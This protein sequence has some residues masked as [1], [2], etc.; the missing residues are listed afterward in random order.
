MWDGE[1]S[2]VTVGDAGKRVAD[3]EANVAWIWGGSLFVMSRSGRD[4]GGL[5]KLYGISINEGRKSEAAV[6]PGYA[7]LGIWTERCHQYGIVVDSW[8]N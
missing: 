6:V 4:I 8:D 2:V 5:A 7:N 3:G 1:R